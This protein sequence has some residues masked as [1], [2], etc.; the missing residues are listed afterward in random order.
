MYGYSFGIKA[1]CL[2]AIY[3]YIYIHIHMYR[4]S[5][6]DESRMLGIKI[7]TK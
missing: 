7:A 1:I 3:V 5:W 6:L 2:S 4:E